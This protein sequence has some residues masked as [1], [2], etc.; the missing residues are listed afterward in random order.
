[1]KSQ[2]IVSFSFSDENWHKKE[3]WDSAAGKR[4]HRDNEENTKEKNILSF[5]N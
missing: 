1:M 5:L 2:K 4:L 3:A